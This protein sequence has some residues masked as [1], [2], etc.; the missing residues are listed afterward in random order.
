MFGS[1]TVTAFRVGAQVR[2]TS[3]AVTDIPVYAGHGFAVG[4]KLIVTDIAGSNFTS[5]RYSTVSAIDVAEITVGG[6]I[7]VTAGELLVNLG[8]D[9]G[10]GSPNYDGSPLDIHEKV[11]DFVPGYTFQTPVSGASVSIGS[12]G[13][14]Q[15]WTADQ[16]VWELIR[17]EEESPIL[18]LPDVLP[19]TE[20]QRILDVRQF[21]ARGSGSDDD[22][23]AIQAA[24][25]AAWAHGSTF[26]TLA[27]GGTVYFPGG[28]YK[29]TDTLILRDRVALVGCNTNTA[30]IQA[31]FDAD[32]M[33]MVQAPEI[34]YS[35]DEMHRTLDVL[36][37][38]LTF[39]KLGEG[40]DYIGIDFTQVGR[41]T[42]RKCR[43]L[44]TWDYGQGVPGEAALDGGI[45]V[46][47]SGVAYRNRL[48]D[49]SVERCSTGFLVAN[50]ANG[51]YL[52]NCSTLLCPTGIHLHGGPNESLSSVALISCN[53]ER[54]S[55]GVKLD[56]ENDEVVADITIVGGHIESNTTD[57]P[58]NKGID[59]ASSSVVGLFVLWPHYSGTSEA[60]NDPSGAA[61]DW[62]YRSGIRG[63]RIGEETSVEPYDP[64]YKAFVHWDRSENALMFINGDESLY[65]EFGYDTAD[66]GVAWWKPGQLV[67]R[68]FTNVKTTTQA[69]P[70]DDSIPEND[71]GTEMMI[72][73]IHPASGGSLL[74][75][76]ASAMVAGSDAENAQMA[77]FR[78]TSQYAFAAVNQRLVASSESYR[79][80]VEA[81]LWADSNSRTSITAR[82]GIGGGKTLTLN[83]TGGTR[84]FEGTARSYIEVTEYRPP[85]SRLTTWHDVLRTLPVLAC[86]VADDPS[87]SVGAM[88]SWNDVGPYGYHLVAAGG[89]EP[90]C[91]ASVIGGRKVVRFDGTNDYL[92]SSIS[93][94][95]EAHL[96]QV[97]KVD[98][99]PSAASKDGWGV[100]GTGADNRYPDSSDDKIWNGFARDTVI[101]C[102]DPTPSLASPHLF[103]V[104]STPTSFVARI[105]G[106]VQVASSSGAVAWGGTSIVGTN[107]ATNRFLDGDIACIL[108]FHK[109]LGTYW[110]AELRS[111]LYT[112]Y[113]L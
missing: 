77:L 24:I 8:P 109:E 54:F 67:R 26:G 72:A 7:S 15:Y 35:G 108:I 110:A 17:D 68:E 50:G 61:V 18:L 96:F 57:W 45:G 6:A 5:L 98:A 76:R 27:R 64:D 38:H 70:L 41:G 71:E 103:E 43:V 62:F 36:I 2:Q 88:S 44:G 90:T 104:A 95:D 47:V 30:T 80:E 113:G 63:L 33:V 46:K 85:K 22:T 81:D 13:R 12:E 66:L 86:Y 93:A 111:F 39:R 40:E 51:T 14:Y 60:L 55:F 25:D 82:L 73:A 99:D 69:I 20:V 91:V 83:G 79:L 28:I 100:F 75:V 52:E 106:T 74:R 4:D 112:W 3:A 84:L 31:E 105:D 11:Y 87:V 53:P 97:L 58:G 23:L 21:G 101:D 10:G 94:P 1:G 19:D 16:R 37:E 65:P 102:G 89:N 59:V 92:T 56:A 9:S 107:T 78:G 49:V 32:D 34:A 42:I 48:E 29:I